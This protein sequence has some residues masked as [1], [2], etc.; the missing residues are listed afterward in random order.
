MTTAVLKLD[1]NHK[2]TPRL[3]LAG[4]KLMLHLC[5]VPDRNKSSFFS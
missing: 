4:L 2:N 5:S 1:G 3:T